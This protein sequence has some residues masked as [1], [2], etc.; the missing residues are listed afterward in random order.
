LA[1]RVR[2]GLNWIGASSLIGELIR[3]LRS[4]VLA[5][6]LVP[7]D[8]GLFGM[9]LTIMAALSALTTIGLDQ[10]IVSNKFDS[11]AELHTYL[12]TVW[13]VEL[14]RSL[15]ITLLVAGSA[16]P[17]ARF[18]G[19][20]NLRLIIPVLG[21]TVLVQGFQNIGLVLLRKEISFARIFWVEL[22][23]NLVG[24]ALT[25]ALG[26][27][28]RNVW[29]LVLGL[30]LTAALGTVLSYVFHSYRPRLAFDKV[31]LRRALGLGKFVLVIA[32]ATYLT[33]MVDNVAVGRLLGASA[34]GNYSLAYNVAS[35]PYGV[36]MVAFARVLFPAYAE[37]TADQSK[38]LERA[39]TKVFSIS[40]LILFTSA[41]PLFL[42]SRELVQLLF[43]DRWTSAGTVLQVL[44]LSIPLRGLT[45]I[46]S[47]VFVSLNRLKQVAMAR[48]LEAIV[49][50]VLLFPLTRSF[51]LI[52][53]AWAVVMAYVF[54][55]GY[56]LV[57]LRQI[58]PGIS[59]K[60]LGVFLSALVAAAVGMLI[61]GQAIIF[62]TAPLTRLVLGGLLGLIIPPAILLLIRS[63]LRRWLREWFS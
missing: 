48:V 53:T 58:I 4:I 18:Y 28:M 12:D 20:P 29:A 24:A 1:K 16:F 45:Q 2:A 30:L 52:G 39:F 57:T 15:V 60:L 62:F 35:A 33:T 9:A 32:I 27:V 49:F 22:A 11:K 5:R 34:L 13:S 26:V 36:L 14:V 59:S 38:R 6:L 44:A 41:V 47:T 8:F 40:A 19:Q 51:G 17:M 10:T 42:L 50:L 43:G 37:I 3:F 23:T 46:M 63:D 31:A 55:C 61:A 25:V 7:E 21:L 54:A 56:R